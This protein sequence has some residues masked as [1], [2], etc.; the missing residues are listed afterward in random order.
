MGFMLSFPNTRSYLHG[1]AL[2]SCHLKSKTNL[3]RWELLGYFNSTVTFSVGTT[4]ACFDFLLTAETS[5]A[6]IISKTPPSGSE[7]A[8]LERNCLLV[9]TFLLVLCRLYDASGASVDTS[10]SLSWS[11]CCSAGDFWREALR[12]PGLSRDDPW[13]SEDGVAGLVL[14]VEDAFCERGGR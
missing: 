13:P 8:C 11:K 9:S 5:A 2:V 1:S 3:S 4:T 7:N 12:F 6:W 14:A 10:S